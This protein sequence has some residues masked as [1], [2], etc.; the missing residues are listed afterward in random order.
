MNSAIRCINLFFSIA[1]ISTLFLSTSCSKKGL[2]INVSNPSKLADKADTAKM[3][4]NDYFEDGNVLAGIRSQ[5][6]EGNLCMVPFYKSTIKQ[7]A[8]KETR[9]EALIIAFDGKEYWTKYVVYK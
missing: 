1:L 6:F 5:S 3:M 2:K 4:K 8:S 7:A 9:N